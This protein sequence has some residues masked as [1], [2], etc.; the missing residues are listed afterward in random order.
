MTGSALAAAATYIAFKRICLN[1][2]YNGTCKE[3][4]IVMFSNGHYAEALCSLRKCVGIRVCACVHT[5]THKTHT[6]GYVDIY[7]Y[8]ELAPTQS[9]LPFRN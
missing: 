3:H 8:T 9:Q 1:N 5:Q 4:G 6:Q 7:R 2:T